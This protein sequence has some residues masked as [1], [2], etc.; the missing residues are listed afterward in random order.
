MDEAESPPG[1]LQ[2]LGI[3]G[4]PS[5]LLPG[6]ACAKAE[7]TEPKSMR[8]ALFLGANA[9]KESCSLPYNSDSVSQAFALARKQVE[10]AFFLLTQIQPYTNTETLAS[11][12]GQKTKDVLTRGDKTITAA[13]ELIYNSLTDLEELLKQVEVQTS[14]FAS[15][16][17]KDADTEECLIAQLETLSSYLQM[18]AMH[19]PEDDYKSGMTQQR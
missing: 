9:L 17:I 7:S 18:T 8:E 11:L 13:R 12:T 3:V 6:I 16:S 15:S 2:E 5:S 19:L 4:E 10:N 14:A 1:L